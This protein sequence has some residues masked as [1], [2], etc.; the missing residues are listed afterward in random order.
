MPRQKTIITKETVDA[1][2]EAV[3]TSDDGQEQETPPEDILCFLQR[4]AKARNVVVKR[5]DRQTGRQVYVGQSSP[6]HCTEQWIQES[7]GAGT[8][9]LQLRTA[10][11]HYIAQRRI[12]IGEGPPKEKDVSPLPQANPG[13][14][15]VV[16]MLQMQVQMMQSQMQAQTQMFAS[17]VE[18]LSGNGGTP[19]PIRDIIEAVASLKTMSG[20]GDS[21]EKITNMIELL[22][23]GIEIGQTGEVR[24]KREGIMDYV[25][26]IIPVVAK[27]LR[28]LVP[29][30][31]AA[32]SPD[33]VSPG[34]PA[35]APALQ[36]ETQARIISMVRQGLNF[37]KSRALAGKS[38][39]FWIESV[40]DNADLPEYRAFLELL[41]DKSY[42]EIAAIDPDLLKPQFRPWFEKLFEG[43]KAGLANAGDETGHDDGPAA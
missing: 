19:T 25:K 11:G 21:G 6:E 24:E 22:Q 31:G 36:D 28:G 15:A 37:M 35:P 27:G 17:M 9:D 39:D 26:E 4:F 10:E 7:F 33:P 43:I 2:T 30:N 8:Y 20:G 5:L 18:K 14:D 34:G 23:K 42:D 41:G 12:E 40:L 1:E 3:A 29:A 32:R 38:T 13:N 16:A